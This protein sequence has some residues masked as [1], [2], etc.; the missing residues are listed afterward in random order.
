M[1][2]GP[3]NE[4][5]FAR[6]TLSDGGATRSSVRPGRLG[7]ARSGIGVINHHKDYLQSLTDGIKLALKEGI[8]P[9]GVDRPMGPDENLCIA[10]HRW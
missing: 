3:L 1:V 5:P 6:P 4:T 7:R 10:V 8:T 9:T 2:Y